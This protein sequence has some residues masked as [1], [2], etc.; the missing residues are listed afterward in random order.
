MHVTT[1]PAPTT[2][3]QALLY[4]LIALATCTNL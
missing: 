2:L 3:E 4:W 1:G